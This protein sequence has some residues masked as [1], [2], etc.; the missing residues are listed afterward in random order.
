MNRDERALAAL[1]SCSKRLKGLAATAAETAAAFE[2]LREL[3]VRL[4]AIGDHREVKRAL[5]DMVRDFEASSRYLDEGV[6]VLDAHLAAASEGLQ[7]AITHAAELLAAVEAER[8][9]S[10]Q[11]APAVAAN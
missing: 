8:A 2:Q 9:G 3:S 7:L 6:N 4:A 10:G 5:R 1:D 11:L